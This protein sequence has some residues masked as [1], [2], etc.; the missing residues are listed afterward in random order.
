MANRAL[1]SI[2]VNRV[3]NLT[4]LIGAAQGALDLWEWASQQEGVYARAFTDIDG[5]TRVTRRD[6]YEE[7]RR[8]ADE[9]PLDHLCIYFAGHGIVNSNYEEVL[10]LTGAQED[11]VEAINLSASCTLARV[12]GIGHVTFISDAC[13]L[14]PA[15][16]Q[17]LGTNGSPIFPNLERE[18]SEVNIDVLYAAKPSKAAY[19]GALAHQCN[20]IFTTE[21][22]KAI[23]DP[24]GNGLKL[25]NDSGRAA[26]SCEEAS[27]FLRVAVPEA[28]SKITE[29]KT[30]NPDFRIESREPKCL[31]KYGGFDSDY[32]SNRSIWPKPT[33]K[34]K[35]VNA[36]IAI[37][38]SRAVAG[39]H[40]PMAVAG[41]FGIGEGISIPDNVAFRLIGGKRNYKA[42]LT[43]EIPNDDNALYI[44]HIPLKGASR[45]E[46]IPLTTPSGILPLVSIPGYVATV[47][48]SSTRLKGYWYEPADP[49]SRE[50]EG[51][52]AR[53]LRADVSRRLYR[54]ELTLS[55]LSNS[56]FADRIRQL[57]AFDPM[58]G[59]V[60]AYVYA[61]SGRKDQIA[62]IRSFMLNDL[63]G[64]EIFDVV[65]LA[66]IF[67]M[68]ENWPY[69]EMLSPFPM[70]SRGWAYIKDLPQYEE[71]AWMEK[72]L[73][74]G[75]WTQFNQ[76][77]L[78]EFR[79]RSFER[80]W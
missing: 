52:M 36:D 62:S 30:Q 25:F 15:N 16:F 9:E 23:R 27:A 20:G 47:D 69:M 35:V 61:E 53:T 2:G 66:R 65:M 63:Q 41:T 64:R 76:S 50:N 10:F 18:E 17:Q 3:G 80:W 29:V 22:L 19:E 79:P 49:W 12:S 51:E 31:S 40:G 7:I 11:P 54:G 70:L 59:V 42:D 4:P 26:L 72:A 68:A 38:S 75:I 8:L 6:I 58:L 43:F 14:P 55:F 44:R 71:I 37:E 33:L 39:S 1:I 73:V 48:S 13:R 45:R 34:E 78:E 60:A 24:V 74:P 32:K 5:T 28:L 46:P 56:K 57:K 21:L 67:G 77:R